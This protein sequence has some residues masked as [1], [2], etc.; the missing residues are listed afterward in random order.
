M[1]R[2]DRPAV[3]APRRTLFS[4]DTSRDYDLPCGCFMHTTGNVID[5]MR[6]AKHAEREFRTLIRWIRKREVEEQGNG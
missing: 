2:T 4:G 3:P 6:C 1:R 5:E